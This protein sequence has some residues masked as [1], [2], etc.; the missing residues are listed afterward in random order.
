MANVSANVVAAYL[1]PNRPLRAAVAVDDTIVIHAILTDMAGLPVDLTGCD[2]VI[3][4]TDREK[5]VLWEADIL[6][7]AAGSIEAVVQPDLPG[8]YRITAKV[9]VPLMDNEHTFFLGSFSVAD[10]QAGDPGPTIRSYTE[11]IEAAIV[12]AQGVAD[13]V[14]G[15][16]ASA[17]AYKTAAQDA[18]SAAEDSATA[19]A[20]SA[21]DASDSAGA[22]AGSATDASGSAGDAAASALAASRSADAAADSAAS[23]AGAVAALFSGASAGQTLV[24]TADGYKWDYPC[25]A[26]LTEDAW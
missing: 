1:T 9:S 14:S 25:N 18:A 6:N 13:D 16:A 12:L 19:A 23:A 5:T 3:T 10:G 7:A 11:Q 26:G 20:G 17:L 24:K 2:V 15:D 22:A 21:S 8:Q 4:A